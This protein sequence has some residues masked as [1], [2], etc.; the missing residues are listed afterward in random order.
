MAGLISYYARRAKDAVLG[1]RRISAGSTAVKEAASFAPSAGGVGERYLV[2]SVPVQAWRKEVGCSV[3]ADTAVGGKR[4]TT[5]E[6]RS[7]IQ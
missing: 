6:Y 2:R 4:T 1:T 3:H 5:A 7:R